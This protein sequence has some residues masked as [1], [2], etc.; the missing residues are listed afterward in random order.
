[1]DR[2]AGPAGVPEGREDRQLLLEEDVVIV[3]RIAEQGKRLGERA[4]TQ[5]HFGPPVGAGVEGAET[6]IDPDRVIRAEHGDGRAEPEPLGAAG[7][8][9]EQNFRGADGEVGTVVLPDAEEVHADPVG[10]LGFG[11]HVAEDAGLR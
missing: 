5:D 2:L 4:A 3:E 11:D 8:G 7:D 6:L 10:Q 9:G 1:M